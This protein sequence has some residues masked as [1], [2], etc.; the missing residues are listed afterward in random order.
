M[1]RPPRGLCYLHQRERLLR[2]QKCTGQVG[3][4]H[5]TPLRDR[6]V[7]ERHAGDVDPGV[8][9]EDVEPAETLLRPGEECAY[10]LGIAH[11]CGVGKGAGRAARFID[12]LVQ[13]VRPA[14]R[15][16]HGIAFLQQRERDRFADAAPRARHERHLRPCAHV[17]SPISMRPRRMHLD[18]QAAGE[19]NATSTRPAGGGP[20]SARRCGKR[21]GQPRGAARVNR[22]ARCR[23]ESSR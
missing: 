1:M 8:V 17:L 5:R 19:P 11:V 9:E 13:R 21:S 3:I 10:G 18:M 12:R 15:Q 22:S 14:A 6:E 16:H 2:A 7:L 4:D 20:R 23:V